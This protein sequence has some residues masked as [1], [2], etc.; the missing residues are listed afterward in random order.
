MSNDSYE[1]QIIKAVKTA[2]PAVVSVVISKSPSK[3][4][5]RRLQSGS[6]FDFWGDVFGLPVP[7]EEIPE[8]IPRMPDG[9]IKIGGGSGFIV[10][11]SGI[12]LTNRHVII[13]KDASYTVITG[14]GKEYPAQILA[15]DP[16]NDVA[17]LK[18]NGKPPAGGFPTVKLGDSLKLELA[19]TAIAI[20]NALGEFQNT[21]STG[22]VSGLSRYITAQAEPYGAQSQLRGLIQTDAAIN[23][24][25][26]GGPLI[27]L[28]GEAVGINCAVVF[29]AQ[30]IG[31]AIPINAAKKDLDDL[32]KYGKIR[33]PFLGIRYVMLNKFLAKRHDLPVFE[34]A[35][36]VKESLNS[37]AVVKGSAA[38]RA[39]IK[40][41]DIIVACGGEKITEKNTVIDVIQKR[42]IGD[43]LEFKILREQKEL[44]IKFKLEERK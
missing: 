10:D 12:I 16:L 11:S 35:W 17:I 28:A 24:G 5:R 27:N 19:Q 37:P 32:K 44:N 2:L 33:R 7:N 42:K 36:V 34:G 41:N 39:K 15:R 21:I 9:K 20:G 25:N 22:I 13:D 26:S 31:F 43:I 18:I 29:G 1:Q 4:F 23:P 6:P 40:E 8:N 38:D 30:N 14:E 3:I